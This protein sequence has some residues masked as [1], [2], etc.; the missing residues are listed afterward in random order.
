MAAAVTVAASDLAAASLSTMSAV[1]TSSVHTSSAM[2][3]V[4]PP[5]L[6]PPSPPSPP[7]GPAVPVRRSAVL[8]TLVLLAG[9]IAL[10]SVCPHTRRG[11]LI[12]W[13]VGAPSWAPYGHR[14]RSRVVDGLL[15]TRVVDGGVT[16]TGVLSRQR[17]NLITIVITHY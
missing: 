7:S 5:S 6:P 14:P 15:G 8:G 1:H 3:T 10:L 12:R 17:G 9:V 2:S 13:R 4:H 11:C 16:A